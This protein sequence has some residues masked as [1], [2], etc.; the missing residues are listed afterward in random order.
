[1]KSCIILNCDRLTGFTH[2]KLSHFRAYTII[3]LSVGSHTVNIDEKTFTT[4]PN[5]L[6][7]TNN[8]EEFSIDP[9]S[10]TCER[11][12]VQF[13]FDSI[14]KLTAYPELLSIFRNRPTGF[15]PCFEATE[16][17]KEIFD[18]FYYEY[19]NPDYFSDEVIRGGL[20]L[21]LVHLFR[22]NVENFPLPHIQFKPQVELVRLDIEKNFSNGLAIADIAA[23]F[24]LNLYYLSHSFKALTGYSPKHFILANQLSLAKELLL[25]TNLSITEISLRCGFADLSSFTRSFSL[26]FHSSPR[27]YRKL[28]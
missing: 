18:S 1:M 15:I 5:S 28:K 25:T 23:K 17:T 2:A 22:Q 20:T 24:D 27:E 6:I 12:I 7:F 8:L 3:F 10:S 9:L 4:S 21:L 26:Q 13:A 14:G 16:H 11:L 19:T